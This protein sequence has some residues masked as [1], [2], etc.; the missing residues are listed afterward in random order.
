MVKFLIGASFCGAA[1]IRRIHLLE[2][3]AYSDLIV[4]GALII[5]S[6]EIEEHLF[7][8]SLC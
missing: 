4:N 7:L 8:L 1:L 2:G 6:I 3:G 5:R